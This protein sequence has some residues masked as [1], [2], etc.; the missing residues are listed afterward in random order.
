M[1]RNPENSIFH[2]YFKLEKGNY[3]NIFYPN[4]LGNI[5][6]SN[7]SNVFLNSNLKYSPINLIINDYILKNSQTQLA[8]NQNINQE[9]KK[10][11]GED[12]QKNSKDTENNLNK[13]RQYNNT[14][15][16]KDYASGA[17]IN[18][19]NITSKKSSNDLL[20]FNFDEDKTKKKPAFDMNTSY[21]TKLINKHPSSNI[22]KTEDNINKSIINT[23]TNPNCQDNINA[24]NNN[25]L[26][27]EDLIIGSRS[28]KTTKDNKTNIKRVDFGIQNKIEQT[29]QTDKGQIKDSLNKT[30][31]NSSFNSIN[32]NESA[33]MEIDKNSNNI[34]IRFLE[35]NQEQSNR[36]KFIQIKIPNN[37]SNS[38]ALELNE[39]SIINSER[40]SNKNINEPSL[41]IEITKK[42]KSNDSAKRLE[43]DNISSNLNSQAN[44]LQQ[45]TSLADTNNFNRLNTST[46]VN[47]PGLINQCRNESIFS[48]L[49]GL[50]KE[51]VKSDR[52]KTIKTQTYEIEDLS[53]LSIN[54]PSV[55]SHLTDNKKDNE[56]SNS[57][58][59]SNKTLIQ[60]SIIGDQ[61][62]EI[63]TMQNDIIDKITEES[64]EEIT[65]LNIPVYETDFFKYDFQEKSFYEKLKN[66]KND[67]KRTKDERYFS[68]SNSKSIHEKIRYKDR[69]KDRDKEREKERNHNAF[70]FNEKISKKY[71]KQ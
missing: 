15:L 66:Y 52:E 6:C 18:N 45:Q 10:I 65:E 14:N 67:S 41:E 11:N 42:D 39:D 63:E 71:S 7:P 40:K 1:R 30:T 22:N 47:Y 17:N 55:S 53:S 38:E 68:Y 34:K 37:K 62:N 44:L 46:N 58:N 60:S 23:N 70:M 19:S 56:G 48:N 33:K 3:D 36:E 31:K 26:S 4:N 49:T 43:I 54:K 20:S 64:D 69:E 24:N 5:L 50:L 51:M 35:F 32:N 12:I 29:N 21:L 27:L 8:I 57:N 13:S 16:N 59:I 28:N 2:N 25:N 61:N 9:T